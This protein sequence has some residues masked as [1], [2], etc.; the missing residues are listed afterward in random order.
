M[1]FMDSLRYSD[2][3]PLSGIQHF[4][5]CQRQW[6]LIH[7]EQQWN[8]NIYTFYGRVLH[9]RV[10]DPSIVEMRGDL[11]TSRSVPIV[12]ESL[13]LYGVADVVEFVN[14]KNGNIKLSNHPGFWRAYPVEYKLGKPKPTNIDAVQLCAQ[15]ICLEEMFNTEIKVAYIYYGRPRRRFEVSL[16]VTLRE[17]TYALAKAMHKMYALA[18]T[19]PAEMKKECKSCSLVDLCMPKLNKSKP[20][21]H[22]L[23]LFID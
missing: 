6:A 23:H 19:P 4:A 20:V 17:E 13:G 9:E 12:S 2:Y 15:A 1:S 3:L 7:I 18:E 10:D 11:I 22:Y 16:D 14:D 21:E 5:F 8:E